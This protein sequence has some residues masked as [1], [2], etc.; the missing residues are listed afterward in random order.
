MAWSKVLAF[1]DPFLCQAAIQAADVELFPRSKGKFGAEVV[2]IRME[3]L[4]M[5]R[6]HVRWPQV[7]AATMKSDRRVIGFL[8]DEHQSAMQHCGI[9]VVFGDIIVNNFEVVHQRSN[10][11]FRYGSMS[12]TTD[13]LNAAIKAITGREFSISPLKRL[14]RPSPDLLSRLL[15]HHKL[16]GE[17]AR[18]AS[19]ILALPEVT[20]A[21]ERE[22]IH[23]MIRCLTEGEA[24][25]ATAG[26]RRHDAIVAR[27]EEYLEANPD[28]PLYLA[29][30]CAAIGVAER[31]LRAACEEHLGMG[32]VRYLNLRRMHLVKRALVRANPS[33]A[34]VTQ[35]ATDHGFWELG[36]FAVTYRALFGE[37]PSE[38]LRRPSDDARVFLNRPSSLEGSVLQG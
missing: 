22:M 6:F 36:R 34:T 1:S 35:L 12:L 14:I 5:Q 19:G 21:L 29:E 2:K 30:I 38:T 8:T 31:T 28:T 4:W 26:V 3:Q 32:P 27:L 7:A 9:E 37:S 13:D 18:T 15:R 11:D 10:A 25:G 24:L 17:M 16:V 33:S 20:R 23:L